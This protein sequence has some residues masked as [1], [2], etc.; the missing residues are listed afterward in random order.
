MPFGAFLFN[1]FCVF[2]DLTRRQ[3]HCN[4]FAAV[5]GQIPNIGI[6]AETAQQNDFIY[7]T[8]CHD[9]ILQSAAPDSYELSPSAR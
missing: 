2:P 5:I 6:G 1:V 7:T 3:T 4:H 8:I 9:Q